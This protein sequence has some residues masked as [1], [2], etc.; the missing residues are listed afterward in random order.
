MDWQTGF[1]VYLHSNF[2]II[3]N[4][5]ERTKTE[6]LYKFTF[7]FNLFA[8]S[9]K[10]VSLCVCPAG[11]A[12]LSILEKILTRGDKINVFAH[13]V[14]CLLPQRTFATRRFRA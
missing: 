6:G 5:F 9:V 13:N 10:G 4:C 14:C 8:R 1:T 7:G 11:L 12:A 2:S 3:Q